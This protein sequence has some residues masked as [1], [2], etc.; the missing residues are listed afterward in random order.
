MN[1]RV[2][3]AP[4]TVAFNRETWFHRI[5]AWLEGDKA[6]MDNPVYYSMEDAEMS[7]LKNANALMAGLHVIEQVTEAVAERHARG[8]HFTLGDFA[9]VIAKET[10]AAVKEAGLEDHTW[11][12][13]PPRRGGRKPAG[14]DAG[15]QK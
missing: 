11:K 2:T 3:R 4:F 13:V 9:N 1:P 14:E 8:E 6:R 7:M 12:P 5:V 10:P 15:A